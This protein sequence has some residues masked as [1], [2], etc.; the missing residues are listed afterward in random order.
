MMAAAQGIVAV[1]RIAPAWH[2]WGYGSLGDGAVEGMAM[3]GQNGYDES[4]PGTALLAQAEREIGRG[5]L[6]KGAGLAWQ[7]TQAALSACAARH[8]MPC[9]NWDDAREL[10]VY[11]D[12]LASA[13]NPF[14]LGAKH[15]N[16]TALFVAY[17]FQEHYEMSEDLVD[18]GMEWEPDEYQLF[19]P[20]VQM[21][22]ARLNASSQRMGKRA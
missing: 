19:L 4:G 6:R 5:N 18:S 21:L 3:D 13:A 9:A 12:Q 20:S 10:A 8:G 1:A 16:T 17:D 14:D 22:I 11:L 15:R 2:N 7:A